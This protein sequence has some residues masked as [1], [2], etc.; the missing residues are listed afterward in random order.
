MRDFHKIILNDLSF[1]KIGI[2][3]AG[4][5]EF[6]PYCPHLLSDLDEILCQE[7]CA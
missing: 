6:C 3:K 5:N 2:T 7:I 4:V 1:V